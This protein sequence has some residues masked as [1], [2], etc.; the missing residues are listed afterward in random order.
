MKERFH[1]FDNP[2]I[3]KK[4]DYFIKFR[5]EGIWKKNNVY[6]VFG[7]MEHNRK[8][9]STAFYFNGNGKVYF[10]YNSY[11]EFNH[12]RSYYKRTSVKMLTPE[13]NQNLKTYL[14]TRS[15]K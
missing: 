6:I 10:K 1:Q 5:C 15:G 3:L 11:G 12:F 8:H 14:K 13:A 7:T 2:V 4:S 9:V